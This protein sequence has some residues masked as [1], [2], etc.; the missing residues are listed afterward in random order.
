M[1]DLVNIKSHVP[2]FEYLSDEDKIFSLEQ[3]YRK[4]MKA[5]EVDRTLQEI[6][7]KQLKNKGVI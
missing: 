6:I 7:D 3:I 1:E 5:R 2:N 4:Q